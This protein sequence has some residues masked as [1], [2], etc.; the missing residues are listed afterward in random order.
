[1]QERESRVPVQD[2][3]RRA[4]APVDNLTQRRA[5]AALR[6]SPVGKTQ[7]GVEDAVAKRRIERQLQMK[8]QSS[9]TIAT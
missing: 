5:A 9:A 2:Y 8:N 7:V 6:S 4:A 1:M 3:E